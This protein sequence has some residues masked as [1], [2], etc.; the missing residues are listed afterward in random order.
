MT[1]YIKD[2][3]KSRLYTCMDCEDAEKYLGS[4]VAF[5]GYSDII[6]IEFG[7]LASI[8][9]KG[10]SKFV[11]KNATTE[12]ETTAHFVYILNEKDMEQF[13]EYGF[14]KDWVSEEKL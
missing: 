8:D 14:N 4:K 1:K 5:G 11:I 12:K 2:F 13:D 7:T 6:G 10:V 9:Y 3:D